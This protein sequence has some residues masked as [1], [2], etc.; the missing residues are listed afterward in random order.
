MDTRLPSGNGQVREA[1]RCAV[2]FKPSGR[3]IEVPAGTLLLDAAR[4]AGVS[5]ETPCGGYGRCGRCRVLVESGDVARR[6]T[7]HLTADEVAQGHALACQ[8]QVQGSLTVFV[9]PREAI[10]RRY[11]P[12]EEARAAQIALP[13]D[14][15]FIC[16]PSL[17]KLHVAVEGPSM[18]DNTNDFDRLGRDL[19]RE[20]G[21][22]RLRADLP[23]LRTLAADVRSANWDVTAVV[24]D[25][26]PQLPQQWEEEMGE[27]G[28]HMEGPTRL[29][30]VEPGDTTGRALGVAVDIGTTTVVVY[31]VNTANAQVLDTASAYNAQISC[32]D[33]VISRIIYSQRGDGLNHL[34]K[35]VTDTINGLLDELAKRNGIEL[36]DI[37]EMSVA[38]NTTM[39]HL[40]LGLNPKYVRE[41]PYIP[42]VNLPPAVL[43]ADL[44]IPIHPQARV[45]CAPGVG[46]YVGGD[47]TAG[48]LSSGMFRTDKLT[49]F[50]DVGTNGE[51]VLG[52]KE[53]LITCACSAGPAFEGGGV[54]DGMRAIPGAVQ[55]VWINSETLEPTCRT[56]G[57]LPPQGICGSGLLGA[58][59]EMFISGIIDKGGRM[60]RD[61]D[62]PRVRIANNIAE[63]VLVKAGEQGA[64]RDI[65]LTEADINNLLRAK[66]AIY[67]GF[68]VLV[69]S[70]GLT[71]A[72]VEQVMIAGAFGQHIHIEKAIQIGL[73][74]DMPW[75]RIKYV[76]NSSALGAYFALVCRE[77][78]AALQAVARKMTYLELS[79]DNSFM[80]EYTRALFL[81]HTDINEFPSV[82]RL[83]EQ[84][85]QK[86]TAAVKA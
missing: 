19:V 18:E 13:L 23:V 55:E 64:K 42:T 7:Y 31:L 25:E 28:V 69:R 26:E 30:A 84:T 62:T 3:V 72:D 76:G 86:G 8:T 52:N 48:V 57:D 49:L 46:S 9:E 65:V 82:G 60:R 85:R 71:M 40:F 20:Y 73:L 39:T 16:Q 83:L 17:R 36:R 35:L 1:R 38:G 68:S 74:P 2:V 32:G 37:Y 54:K 33:D 14:G 44:G 67:A 21:V 66:G 5:I 34:R 12:Q 29:L 79:A 58:L 56:I 77:A 11:R 24:D 61:L 27:T 47:I 75:D 15:S 78:R 59:A 70:V 10:S 41:A 45:K 80:D 43:A 4:Q 63:Y 22:P 53:W 51:I 6:D 81:P 50:I